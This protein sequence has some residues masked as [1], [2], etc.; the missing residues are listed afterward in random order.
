MNSEADRVLAQLAAKQRG[1]FTFDDA[2]AAGLTEREAAYRAVHRWVREHDGVF[3]I[4]GSAE[5]WESQVYAACRAVRSKP[6][7]I[8]HWAGAEFLGMPFGR[9]DRVELI[10][11]RWKR[12]QSPGLVVHESTRLSELD[13]T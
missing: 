3:R 8:S 5:T 13:I 1:I 7:G 10:C 12:S 6:A 11:R 2:V 9:S 4:P